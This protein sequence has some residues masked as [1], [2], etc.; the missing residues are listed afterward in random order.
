M[1]PELTLQSNSSSS[2]SE[3]GKESSKKV[4]TRDISFCFHFVRV[5]SLAVANAV[6]QKT[7]E[8]K[9]VMGQATSF[10]TSE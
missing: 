6:C 3:F 10:K 9:V 1:A 7:G 2:L 5:V 8:F 4:V